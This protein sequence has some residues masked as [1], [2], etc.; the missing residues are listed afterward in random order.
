MNLAKPFLSEDMTKDELLNTVD[1]L[2]DKFFANG[3]VAPTA[4]IEQIS[5]LFFCQD[6]RGTGER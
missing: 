6:V 5:F 4:Y 1:K 2:A 3:I